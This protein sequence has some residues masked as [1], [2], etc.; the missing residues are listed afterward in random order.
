MPLPKHSVESFAM[1]TLT[2][3]AKGQVLLSEDVLKHLGVRPGDT[4][5]ATK[6]PGGRIELRAAQRAGKISNVFGL[7]RRKGGPKLSIEELNTIAA[8]GWTGRRSR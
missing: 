1:G 4:V 8:R 6:L 7:L 5:T 3:T 2:V